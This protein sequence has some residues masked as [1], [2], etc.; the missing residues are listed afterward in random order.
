MFTCSMENVFNWLRDVK[1]SQLTICDNL[2]Y[3]R[4]YNFENYIV[5]AHRL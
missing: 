2:F 4:Y 5:D 1:I 3:V